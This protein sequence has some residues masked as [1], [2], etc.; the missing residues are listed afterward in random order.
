MTSSQKS[1]LAAMGVFTLIAGVVLGGMTW[2]T[3]ASFELAKNRVNEEHQTRVNSAL[4]QIESRIKGIINFETS[5]RYTDYVDYNTVEPVAVLTSDGREVDAQAVILRSP[6]ALYGP[7]FDWIDLYFQVDHRGMP[8]SP[9]FAEER[10]LWSAESTGGV[11][12]SERRAR[13]TLE[14]FRRALPMLSLRERVSEVLKHERSS[15]GA[16]NEPEPTDV[17]RVSQRTSAP[18]GA[19]RRDASIGGLGRRVISTASGVRYV[20]PEECVAPY[21]AAGNFRNIPVAIDSGFEESLVTPAPVRIRLSSF[22]PPF[23]IDA[24]GEKK[25]LAF[26]RECHADAEILY[27]GLIGDWE[28]LKPELLKPIEDLFP[29]ADLEPVAND[30]D[31]GPDESD[32]KLSEFPAVLRVPDIPG[33]T[34]AAA[35]R[36]IR[37]V[38]LISWAAALTVLAGAGWGVRSLVALTE[39]RMQFAYAVTHELRTPLTTFR[40]YSDMLSAG[41]VP[42]A[43]KQEYLDTLNRESQ[44]LSSLVESVLEYARLEN[45]KVKLHIAATDAASLLRVV[46]ETVQKRCAPNAIEAET[47]NDVP[48][49]HPIHTD[50]NLVN[51]IAAVLVDNACRHA[52][53]SRS[54]KVVVLLGG[55]NGRLQLDVVDSGPGIDLVDSRT[56]FKPFRRGRD[57]DA[58]ARGGIGLGLSLARNWATLLGGKLDLVARHDPQYGG[59]H[60][61]LSIPTDAPAA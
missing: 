37:G 61:R 53:G 29:H 17:V 11:G 44:R 35:W 25:K 51:Q 24:D 46:G 21:I 10:P 9:Q 59:A 27:Q 48:N 3:A 57:A 45:H 12:L 22:A 54:P 39:R 31:L 42:D 30:V 23:W 43:S 49:A 15:H 7:P 52:R 38:L 6:I 32:I 8:S 56:I 4:R 47:R 41:L 40:L 58:K 34:A 60:F 19:E 36:S 16:G 50:V 26:V 13:D 55:D 28:R 18:K 33:G 20:P 5:R 1:T 14:W 2:A